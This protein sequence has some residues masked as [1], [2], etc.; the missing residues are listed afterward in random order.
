MIHSFTC[1]NFYSIKDE[2]EVDF[3]VGKNAPNKSS[4]VAAPGGKRVSLIEAVIGPNAS[5]KTNVLKALPFFRWL[6]VDAYTD[7]PDNNLPIRGFGS[8]SGNIPSKLSV[9]FS[10]DDKRTFKYS[11]VLNRNRIL[12]EKLVENSLTA[13][14]STSK[15]ILF[16]EWV[17]EKQEYKLNDKAFGITKEKLRKNSSVVATAFRDENNLATLIAKY[18]RDGVPTNVR[19]TGYGN[20]QV[21]ASLH[22]HLANQA[23]QFFYDNPELKEQVESI[24]CRYDL[25]FGG[26]EREIVQEKTFFSIKHTFDT[27]DIGLPLE[28][29]SSGTKQII[30]ILQYLLVALAKG[31]IAVIDEL[32][33]NLHPEIV[34][35]VV[36]MFNSKESNPNSAQIFFSSHTPTILSSLDKYQITFI[37]KNSHGQT[38]VW[39]LDSVKGV[40]PDDNY[41][42][43]YIA[44]AYG[45]VPNLG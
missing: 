45:A 15:V 16:R 7:N 9:L 4:Y 42:A 1:E 20:Y 5:G 18:W 23:I 21:T 38:D 31:G 14:R 11:F 39:R 40:R 26:F 37:E 25:G 43:K 12:S 27:K 22:D 44:G 34:E 6:I 13:E 41:Y 24:L 32:D 35:E 29:E 30:I 8:N 33:A 19:E 3:T 36:S 17:E 28:Y 2:V 10:I